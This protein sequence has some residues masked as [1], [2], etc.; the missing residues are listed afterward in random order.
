[1]GL[2]IRKWREKFFPGRGGQAL[3]AK[4]AKVSG[5]T[6]SHYE[7]SQR[8]ANPTL[9]KIS[10]VLGV[11]VDELM[12]G[13][14]ETQK[15][16]SAKAPGVNPATYEAVLQSCLSAQAAI[17]V[18]ASQLKPDRPVDDYRQSAEEL[19]DIVAALLETLS[20]V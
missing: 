10:K 15:A 14:P 18:F 19:K 6:W 8:L 9:K 2:Q 12:A 13:P 1:M 7:T 16:P 20:D 5:A 4:K 3:A 11:S 17:A